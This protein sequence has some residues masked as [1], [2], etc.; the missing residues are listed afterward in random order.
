MGK[1]GLPP[2]FMIDGSMKFFEKVQLT[3]IWS[4]TGKMA[5]R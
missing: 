2:G 4:E 1:H 3:L 5:M